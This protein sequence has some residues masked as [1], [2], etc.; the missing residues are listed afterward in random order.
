IMKQRNSHN[1]WTKEWGLDTRIQKFMGKNLNIPAFLKTAEWFDKK[2]VFTNGFV[3]L[4]F[5]TETEAEIKTTIKVA[6]DSA[7]HVASFFTVTPFANTALARY[8]EE[9]MPDKSFTPEMNDMEY[10]SAKINLTGLPDDVFFS[11]Q[12]YAFQQFYLK[13]SRLFRLMQVYPKPYFLP[14]Y[15]PLFMSRLFKE[16]F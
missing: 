5:P 12:R 1:D 16:L 14:F 2:K 9:H 4:G 3:M 15:L 7:L 6:T 10:W 13:P 11:Y 8:V